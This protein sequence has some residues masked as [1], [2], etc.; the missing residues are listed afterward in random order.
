MKGKYRAVIYLLSVFLVILAILII[1]VI[2]ENNYIKQSNTW[3]KFCTRNSFLDSPG[4]AIDSYLRAIEII[5]KHGIDIKHCE[6]IF[7]DSQYANIPNDA[8]NDFIN[9]VVKGAESRKLG[10]KIKNPEP[11]TIEIYASDGRKF[12]LENFRLLS[13][14]IAHF[15]WLKSAEGKDVPTSILLG[16]TNIALGTQLSASAPNQ[17][18]LRA[19]GI[20][21]KDLGLKTIEKCAPHSDENLMASISEMR[22]VLDKEF[23]IVKNMPPSKASFWDFFSRCM[24]TQD[25]VNETAQ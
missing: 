18:I 8:L 7:K 9:L 2:Y 14:A 11:G 23:E 5:R 24:K 25:D 20:A 17:K 15:A 21:C 4:A 3:E 16:K 10:I 6:D 22:Q 1:Y 13:N 19:R 12:A